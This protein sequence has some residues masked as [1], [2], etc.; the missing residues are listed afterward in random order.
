VADPRPVFL[1][2]CVFVSAGFNMESRD[3]KTLEQLVDNGTLTLVT[4]DVVVREVHANITLQIKIAESIHAKFRSGDVRILWAVESARPLLQR[5]DANAIEQEVHEAFDDYLRRTKAVVL[6]TDELKAAPIL[7]AYFA[8]AAPFGDGEKRKEF[9]DAFS[10]AALRD[11]CASSKE[12]ALALVTGDKGFAAGAGDIRGAE[13][14]AELEDLLDQVYDDARVEFVKRLLLERHAEIV[15]EIKRQFEDLGFY[16][17][18]HFE[19]EVTE[20]QVKEVELGDERDD[21]DIVFLD[22]K[23]ATLSAS[24]TVRYQAEL[25][26]GDE[27]AMSY[28]G[29]D[30]TTTFWSNIEESVARAETVDVEIE[31]TLDGLDPDAFDIERVSLP[32]ED[33]IH[34]EADA[35]REW[36]RAGH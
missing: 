19:G 1:D 25:E 34:V 2:T 35:D 9:P 3:L 36:R 14:F 32:G 23:A 18:D 21:F 16:V 33:T 5:L 31:I 15:K 6:C 20:V 28:D 30:G 12:D 24:A 7:E 11:W 22:D 27:N 26:Y 17:D 8:K 10:I 13:H 4:T 29:E